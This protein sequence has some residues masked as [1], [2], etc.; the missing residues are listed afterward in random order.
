MYTLETSDN[1]TACRVTLAGDLNI[2]H[3]AEVA[4]ALTPLVAQARPLEIDLS[5][6]TEIDSAGVQVL[7][8]GRREALRSGATL[9]VIAQSKSVSA[10]FTEMQVADRFTADT[11]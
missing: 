11:N 4:R 3:A 9:N 7:L 1:G 6:V 2:Y 10:V 8:A 5:G